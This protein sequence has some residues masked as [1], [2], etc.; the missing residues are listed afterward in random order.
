MKNVAENSFWSI[1][2]VKKLQIFDQNYE[3]T[4]L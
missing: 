1:N 3:L 2:K 4:L